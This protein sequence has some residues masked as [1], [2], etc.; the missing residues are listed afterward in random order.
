MLVSPMV[1][2]LVTG[3]GIAI[4]LRANADGGSVPAAG[5][6]LKALLGLVFIEG[7]GVLFGVAYFLMHPEKFLADRNRLRSRR[8]DYHSRRS[9]A[10]D[11]PQDASADDV[12][13]RPE[14]HEPQ[15]VV[16]HAEGLRVPE[17]MVIDDLEAGTA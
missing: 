7:A 2:L 4:L 9:E 8:R 11:E 1:A 6:L 3:L 17:S 5:L 16:H 13:V 15:T 14:R 10:R 12:S